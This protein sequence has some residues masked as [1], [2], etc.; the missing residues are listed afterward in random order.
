[1]TAIVTFAA[2]RASRRRP[3]PTFYKE[4][5]AAEAHLQ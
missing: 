1:M 2:L 4:G 5:T 3:R